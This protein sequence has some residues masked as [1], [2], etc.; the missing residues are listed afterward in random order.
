MEDSVQVACVI[1]NATDAAFQIYSLRRS[2]YAA[3]LRAFCAQSDVLSMGKERCLTELRNELKI[4]QTEHAECLVKARSNKQIKSFSAS[5]H[6]KRNTCS[7]EVIK[8]FPDLQCVLPDTR[9]T[10]FQIHC[11]ER[12]AYAAVLR[13]FCAVTNHLSLVKI[14][15][16]LKNELRISH[17]E[18][19]EILMKAS[20]NEHIKSLRKFS[21]AK[22][23][24]VTK[25][26]PAF[27]VHAMLHDKIGSTGEVCTS[28]TSCL[29]L[30]QQSPISEN[31]MSSTRDI[32]LSDSSNGA[33]E[34]PNFE[35]R[36]VVSAKRLK[37]VNGHAPAYLK[38]GPSN[39]LPVEVCA[40]MVNGCTAD[41]LDCETLC[42]QVKSGCVSSPIFQEK[43]SRLNAG[44]SSLSVDH[45]RKESEKMKS[46]APEM[47]VSESLGV[48]DRKYEIEYQK[49]K[50]K[51]SDLEHGSEIIKLCLTASLLNK[52][53]RIFK[54][55]PD[56]ANL[57]KA[58]LTLKD[59]E[60]DL[61][62]ALAKLSEVA[63]D[64]VYFGADHNHRPVNLKKHDDGKSTEA[65]LPKL[66]SSSDE[67]SPETRLGDCGTEN[68]VK[69]LMA[70]GPASAPLA[71]PRKK[72]VW[73]KL[74][75]EQ[76]ER[77]LEFA[78]RFRWR[79][80]KAGAEAVDAFCAQIGVTQRVF[81]NWINNNR[82][83]AKIPPSALPSHHQDHP[84]AT[85]QGSMTEEGKSLEAEV[86]VSADGG[87]D[88]ENEVSD[89]I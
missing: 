47:S 56:S 15:S 89:P 75:A 11:L 9:D 73:T 17:G 23:S 35:S 26:D 30:I 1:S 49:A 63:Y 32:G 29:S 85:A 44:Q 83:L 74:T 77:M 51:D 27:D 45:A 88:G 67:T 38:C 7:T 12:S 34:G 22:L 58:K 62:D 70:V 36:T 8:D 31:S 43:H 13:A 84:A 76:K 57:E 41:T 10:V 14:L 6:S 46:E 78:Q 61:L 50:N 64:V 71:A 60:K 54:E 19:K 79:V 69:I 87:K 21:L 4:L 65:V 66:V 53:E 52:V 24:V 59:Q 18:Y 81:K 42:C 80:H 68:K 16:E 28:S 72:R 3:V 39:Q 40:M 37:T 86:D 25:N 33:K 55:N 82:H 20:V 5:L 48:V 2:A